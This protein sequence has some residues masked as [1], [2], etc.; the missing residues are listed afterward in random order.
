MKE[1]L[2]EHGEFSQCLIPELSNKLHFQCLPQSQALPKWLRQQLG[3]PGQQQQW[4][5]SYPGSPRA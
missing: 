1:G 2:P 5:E 4:Q 3:S